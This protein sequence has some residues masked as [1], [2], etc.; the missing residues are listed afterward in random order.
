[1]GWWF[2][3]SM[4]KTGKVP[5]CAFAFSIANDIKAINVINAEV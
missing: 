2:W 1:M 5:V 4:Y 3:V